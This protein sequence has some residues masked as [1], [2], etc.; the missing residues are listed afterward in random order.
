MLIQFTSRLAKVQLCH[1]RKQEAGQEKG[2]DYSN[3]GP[4]DWGPGEIPCKSVGGQYI[5][6]G[7]PTIKETVKDLSNVNKTLVRWRVDNSQ[8]LRKQTWNLK[9]K[10]R[11]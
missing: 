8:I 2:Q 6:A 11:D 4:M 5:E 9:W 1:W 7:E 10:E 3:A